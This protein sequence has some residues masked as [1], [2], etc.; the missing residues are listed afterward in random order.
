MARGRPSTSQQVVIDYVLGK[1]ERM[2]DRQLD[3]RAILEMAAERGLRNFDL[4]STMKR[5]HDKDLL[6]PLQYGRWVLSPD[7]QPTRTA[8][9]DNLDIVADAVL[10][11]LGMEYYVSW[12]SALWHYGLVDQQSR[13]IY[14]AVTHRKRP[15]TLGL[16]SVKFVTVAERK[17]FGRTLVEDSEW[18]V[19]MATVEKALIDALDQPHLVA[20]LPVIANSLRAAYREGMLDPE[21]L[22]ADAIRFDSPNLNR[23]LGFFMDLY[24]IPGTDPLALRL[25]R[26]SA[27]PLA[28]GRAPE[29][30]QLPVSRR[31]RVYE[32]PTIIGTALELK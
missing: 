13:R 14:V 10:R 17:F 18:P 25:G 8:R 20:P 15:V 5:L 11:R 21:R 4:A 26:A 27:V 7:A 28:P 30:G 3:S 12:H 23:R 1:G 32:D 22:V 16:A 19:W 2:L 31:W 29:G 6:H 24:S 9:L